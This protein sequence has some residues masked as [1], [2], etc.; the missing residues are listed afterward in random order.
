MTEQEARAL[1]G[2]PEPTE[3]V[4]DRQAH[5]L[6][7]PMPEVT[8]RPRGKAMGAAADS[9]T[10]LD[11]WFRSTQNAL[12]DRLMPNGGPN[13]P[14]PVGVSLYPRMNSSGDISP[15]EGFQTVDV[16]LKDIAK[17]IQASDLMGIGGAGRALNEF[18]YGM[19][20]EDNWDMADLALLAPGLAGLVG[21][22]AKATVGAGRGLAK[23]GKAAK[24]LA[25]S[26]AAYRLANRV[27][28]ATG[29]SPLNVIKPGGGNWV[30]TGTDPIFNHL[31]SNI[32]QLIE[33][34]LEKKRKD[35]SELIDRFGPDNQYLGPINQQIRQLEADLAERRFTDKNLGK[36]IRNQMGTESDPIRK[37]IDQGFYHYNIPEATSLQHRGAMS[38]RL[39]QGFP[40]QGL[41]TTPAGKNWETLS[42]LSIN[43]RP[44]GYLLDEDEMGYWLKNNPWMAKLPPEEQ[45]YALDR[46]TRPSHLGFDKL[47]ETLNA[48]VLAGRIDPE[49]VNT[50]KMEDLVRITHERELERR[51]ELERQMA[52]NRK[53]LPVHKEYPEGYK[54]VELNKPGSFATESDAMNHSV[55]GYEPEKDHPD[56]VPLSGTGGRSNY[57][58]GGWEAIKSGRAKVYSLID[59]NGKPYVTVE[60][61]VQPFNEGQFIS[62]HLDQGKT[63]T[64]EEIEQAKGA[65]PELATQVKR[66]GNVVDTTDYPQRQYVTDFMRHKN[67]DLQVLQDDLKNTGLI[68]RAN[69]FSPTEKEALVAQGRE[70]PEYLTLEEIKKLREGKQWK[71]IDT[72]PEL[73]ID[74]PEV[75]VDNP[76]PRY[77][78]GGGHR[79]P[80]D[81]NNDWRIDDPNYDEADDFKEGGLAHAGGGLIKALSMVKKSLEEA[82]AAGKVVESLSTDRIGM[83]HKDV[84][85]R[86]PE[87]TAAAKLLQEGKISKDEYAEMVRMFKPVNPFAEV[88]RMATK[89]EMLKALDVNQR[90]K[91]YL[92]RNLEEGTPVGGRLNIPSYLRHDTWIP[93]LHEQVPGF[94]AG[95]VIGYDSHFRVGDASFGVEPRSALNYATGKT[96]KGTFAT[97]KGNYKRT[98]EEEAMELAREMM[99][100]PRYRQIGMDPE[101]SSMFYDRETFEPVAEAEDVLQVGPLVFARNPRRPSKKQL[102]DAPYATGG[103]AAYKE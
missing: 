35:Y 36:Y 79:H 23:V 43:P 16:P 7:P 82:K 45:V 74:V 32:A 90:D 37:A 97:I 38:Q 83:A 100:D 59:E 15:A 98:G 22:G 26:D 76:R 51:A 33:H 65:V 58:H 69:V 70:V 102:E 47:L 44:A 75:F 81:P 30:H 88:P 61:E 94:R 95:P 54:W 80:N 3:K 9:L 84:T 91:L 64:A 66:Y 1:L 92:P 53:D 48:E 57:G 5:V 67:F 25:Q 19:T 21:S 49:K 27:A 73:D 87:L 86:V 11:K 71:P 24:N 96:S 101:R 103:A 72:D 4:Y 17:T 42:D 18:S 39:G 60:T 6:K 40:A 8:S 52:S 14:F 77:E 63:P 50:V 89:E 62:K 2:L 85:K 99:S 55:R 28:E 78:I 93:T 12:V 68:K 13:V 20:P 31:D 10:N 46:F 56:W 29:A 34:D 41:A